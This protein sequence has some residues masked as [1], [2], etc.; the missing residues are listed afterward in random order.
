MAGGNSGTGSRTVVEANDPE[1]VST[2]TGMGPGFAWSFT[3]GDPEITCVPVGFSRVLVL[4]VPD[5]LLSSSVPLL[6]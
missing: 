6:V 4:A 1:N 5:V 2:L 3:L